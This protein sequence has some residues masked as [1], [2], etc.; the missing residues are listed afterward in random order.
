MLTERPESS[1]CRG[2]AA[3]V[4]RTGHPMTVPALIAVLVLGVG[5]QIACLFKIPSWGNDEPA[6]LGYVAAIARGDLPT[7]ETDTLAEPEQFGD[8]ARSVEG[9]DEE[10]GDVWTANHAPLFHLTLLPLWWASDG[11]PQRVVIAM[12]L[13]NTLGFALWVLLVGLIARELVPRRPAVPALAAVLAAAPTLTIR[14]GFLMNDGMSSAGALLMLWM[15][16]RMLRDRATGHRLGIAAV[17][18]VLAA[19]T[20]ASG[21]LMVAVCCVVLVTTL[22]RRDGARSA[23][24]AGAV[25]GGVPALLTGWFYV[26]NYQLYGDFTGQSALLD[27]FQRTGVGSLRDL[28][29]I[30]SLDE[31]VYTMP[32]ALLVFAVLVPVVAL[33]RVRWAGLVRDPAWLLLIAHAAITGVQLVQFLRTGGGYH[34]RYLMTVMPL[35]ATAGALAI[36]HVG[37]GS[38]SGG[39][40]GGRDRVDRDQ[41]EWRRAAVWSTVLL[42]WLAGTVT[43]LERLQIFGR[44]PSSPLGGAV[45][46]VLATIAVTAGTL[47]WLTFLARALPSHR[48]AKSS[49]FAHPTKR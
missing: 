18:G 22:W 47:A 12:R 34:D 1:P 27:K 5:A 42:L 4:R 26:R 35:L 24:T 40:C 36:L 49:A 6:H 15:T 48:A 45:P 16:I 30:P 37:R 14:A 44:Q 46:A 32:I 41:R 39:G 33:R 11:E 17:G 31:A 21:V 19:G 29:A 43:W 13:V 20:R 9:W 23:L 28:W 10:H 25:V 38:A 2:V 8:L 7:I 3:F